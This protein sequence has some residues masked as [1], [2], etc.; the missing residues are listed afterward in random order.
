MDEHELDELFKDGVD[1][2][3][4]SVPQQQEG[5]PQRNN[6]QTTFDPLAG[7]F[8]EDPGQNRSTEKSA[9]RTRAPLKKLDPE[10]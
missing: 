10:V 5:V 1:F 9:T 6:A 2:P 7:L 3:E 4:D 8:N